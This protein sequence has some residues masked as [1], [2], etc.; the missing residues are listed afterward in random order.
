MTGSKCVADEAKCGK[1]ET[2]V[3]KCLNTSGCG[4][5]DNPQEYCSVSGGFAT[6]TKVVGQCGYNGE[7]T[8]GKCGAE[9]YEDG[10]YKCKV[11]GVEVTNFYDCAW[12]SGKC[13]PNTSM[14][15]DD[16]GK[17]PGCGKFE[18]SATNGASKV[19]NINGV[20]HTSGFSDCSSNPS[21]PDS[22][23][24]GV[25]CPALQTLSCG[26]TTSV[27]T[28][29]CNC[30]S[31]LKEFVA[32]T[33]SYCCGYPYQ[34]T[35]YKTQADADAAQAGTGGPGDS[36]DTGGDGGSDAFTIFDGPSSETFKKLNPLAAGGMFK[37]A[38][39]TSAELSSPGGIISRVLRF[40]FPIAGLILFVMLVWAGFEILYNA[41]GS[42]SIQQGSQ[43]ATAAIVGFVLL[44]CSYFIM[45]L[46]EIVFGITIL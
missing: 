26:G 2:P 32:G 37:V 39:G 28:Q 27:G 14:C 21:T 38:S 40:A 15:T 10:R 8:P 1:P 4:F 31:G 5:C 20:I 35:C 6:C 44:F 22:C 3:K 45:Q 7:V 41:A 42:K 43:R 36:S 18:E 34:G 46:I 23:C 29:Q 30:G 19:C 12:V 33:A 13:C 16:A 24:Y 9:V 25:S 17:T 11:D